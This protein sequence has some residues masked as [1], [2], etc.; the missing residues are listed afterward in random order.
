MARG[1]RVIIMKRRGGGRRRGGRRRGGRRR[2]GA[3]FVM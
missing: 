3:T 2:G 1:V